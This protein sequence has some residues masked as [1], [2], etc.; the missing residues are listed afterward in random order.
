[1]NYSDSQSFFEI[2]NGP[3]LDNSIRGRLLCVQDFLKRLAILPFALLQKMGKTF[4]R[5]LGVCVG[6]FLI[7]ATAGSAAAARTFFV[8]RIASLARDLAD[9]ILL[10]IALFSC[11]VRLLMGLSFHPHFYFNACV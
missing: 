7:A 1:M 2:S 5:F 4:F 8:E 11:F 6:I 3:Y 9:W 10:P